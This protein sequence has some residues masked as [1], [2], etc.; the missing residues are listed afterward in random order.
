ML[1]GKDFCS[2]LKRCSNTACENF[3]LMDRDVRPIDQ[4]VGGR[5]VM[6][7]DEKVSFKG[8]G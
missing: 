8:T 1:I 2:G 5:A 6:S 4:G 3:G 7:G